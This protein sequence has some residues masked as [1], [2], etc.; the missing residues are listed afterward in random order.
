MHLLAIDDAEDKRPAR[1]T[2]GGF[3]TVKPGATPID[4]AFTGERDIRQAFS[5]NQ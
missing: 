4:R 1:R 2:V 3:V 5:E